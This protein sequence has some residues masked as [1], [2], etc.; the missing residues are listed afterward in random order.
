MNSAPI[1]IMGGFLSSAAIY[2]EMG[3]SLAQLSGRPIF[4]VK[5]RPF[6]WLFSTSMIG[7]RILLDRLDNT[8]KRA[9]NTTT[10]RKLTLIGHSMGGV[11]SRL[12]LNL[13]PLQGHV[14]AGLDRVDHLI[15][16]G[17][18]HYNQGGT[19]RGGRL[20]RWV[21]AHV[22]GAFFSPA[23]QYTSVAGQWLAGDRSGTR[24]AA[25]AYARYAE[26]SG[27][28]AVW[29]DGIIPLESALLEGSQQIILEGVCHYSPTGA[30]WYG[31]EEVIPHWWQGE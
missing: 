30:P 22:P 31:S 25:W 7:W 8:V 9:I 12:Y 11:V 29:G 3:A 10:E 16:L 28:G 24:M 15:S 14:Y 13:E 23:V 19:Q 20:S 18:P 6:E 17:S 2:R 26:I 5:T 21:E 4:I 27:D 1:V